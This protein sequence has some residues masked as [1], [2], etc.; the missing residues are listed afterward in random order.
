[1]VGLQYIIQLARQLGIRGE[2]EPVLSF[3]LGSNVVTLLEAT[4]MYEGLVTGSVTTYGDASSEEGGGNDSQGIIDHI[5]TEDGQ[6]VYQP[7]PV[8]KQVFDPKTTLALGGILENVVKF[9]TGKSASEKVRLRKDDKGGG[10]EIA[11]LNLPIPLLGKTGTANNYTNAS[12]F[13]Y[14]PGIRPNGDGMVPEN[15]YAVGT[16]VGFDDNQP[17]RHKSSRI[18][19]AAGALPTWCE[20][21]NVLMKEQGYVNKLDPVDISFYGLTLKRADYGQLNLGATIDQGGKVVEPV[22]L[23]SEKARTQPSI[24]TFGTKTDTGRFEVERNFRPFWS[25][26]VQASSQ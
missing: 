3:P 25:N 10:A 20:I 14:L 13:G 21:V 24:L 26:T 12:F 17:M 9:G 16:Y 22:V 2:L 8:R 18:S 4:R 19:G 23:V 15:G 7:N 11:K 6:V 1:M 5:E